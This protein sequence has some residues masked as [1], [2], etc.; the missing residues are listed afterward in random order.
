M[1][2]PKAKSEN[3]FSI[4]KKLAGQNTLLVS[5]ASAGIEGGSGINFIIVDDKLQFEV[6][7]SNIIKNNLKMNSELEKLAYKKY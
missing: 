1:F 6:K 7:K 2:I 4:T 5:Y 3:M